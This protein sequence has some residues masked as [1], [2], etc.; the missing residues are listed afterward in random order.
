M[1]VYKCLHTLIIYV[2]KKNGWVNED[3]YRGQEFNE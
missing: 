3:I 2:L 1:T